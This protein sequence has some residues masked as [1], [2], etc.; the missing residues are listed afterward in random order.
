MEWIRSLKTVLAYIEENLRDE[1][2][3]EEM[4]GKVYISPFYLQKGF[5][6]L[7]GYS[8]GEYI[9]NR[10]LYEAAADISR[11]D[12]I[13]DV[14]GRYGYETQESFTKA[15]TRFHGATPGKIRK[16]FRQARIFLPLNIHIE[17]TGGE[18]MDYTVSPMG[19]F[20]VIGFER[21]F[22]Y[23]EAYEKIPRFWDEICEKYCNNTIYAGK[24]PSC[25]EA[26]AI[27][28]YCIGEYGVCIDDVGEGKFRYL[29]AGKYTGGDVPASMTLFEFPQ[30]EWAKFSCT[31]PIPHAL[32]ALNTH[33]F[34][35]W[36]PGNPEFEMNGCYNVEWYSRDGEKSDPDYKSGIWI[37]VRRY[38]DEAAEKWGDTEAYKE[39]AKK[40]AARSKQQNKEAS[41]GMMEI[42]ARFG[43]I[44]EE[45]P[46]SPNAKKLAAELKK[47]ITDNFYNCTDEIFS[48]L[49]DM[50]CADG[51][52]KENIDRKGGAGTA[53]FAAKAIKEYLK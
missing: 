23:D 33:I 25:P 3:I 30:S 40:S 5:R 18:K 37:P 44:K 53:E 2:S 13:I 19:G 27:K 14:A 50:Y 39:N 51:R 49:A 48:G 46:A 21:E 20:K 47:Y 11:G 45:S 34:R 31:G 43:E 26:Q 9:R 15:F 52:F 41:D 16:D 28:D 24:A 4:S 10:R 17:I 8:V 1:I 22:T 12:K 36:L 32:Q 29:I 42:F 6:I 35:E 7:T 38:A